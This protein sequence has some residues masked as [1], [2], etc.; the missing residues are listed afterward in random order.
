MKALKHLKTKSDA[1]I[2]LKLRKVQLT[3]TIYGE[4]SEDEMSCGYNHV[5]EKGE[6][7]IKALH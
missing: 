2:L 1:T 3:C 6:G 4:I 5:L 7:P